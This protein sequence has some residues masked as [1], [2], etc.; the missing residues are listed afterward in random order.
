MKVSEKVSEETREFIRQRICIYAGRNFD[1]DVDGQVV[2]ILRTRFNIHL[3]QRRTLN[4]SLASA[5]SDH[6]IIRLLLQYRT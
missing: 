2:E 6:E 5:N 3:P 4:E 1:P